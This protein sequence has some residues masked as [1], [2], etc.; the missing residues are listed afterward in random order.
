[1][2]IEI[3]QTD[4]AAIADRVIEQ[5]VPLIK[6]WQEPD[7]L[8]D[9]D[10]VCQFLKKSKGQIYQW[11]NCSRHGLSNFPFR[12]A[13]RSLRFSKKDITAWMQSNSRC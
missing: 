7:E 12:K 13:G 1:M 9:I 2:L 3:D 10:Q 11:V 4:I 8:M 6:S 5:L